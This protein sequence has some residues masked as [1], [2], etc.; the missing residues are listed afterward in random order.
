M[1]LFGGRHGRNV[2]VGATGKDDPAAAV[3]IDG[4][5]ERVDQA[6]IE[7]RVTVAPGTARVE[8]ADTA[9]L[10]SHRRRPFRSGPHRAQG[11]DPR[12]SRR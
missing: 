10:G 3:F 1:K 9:P 7:G 4:S 11:T 12:R 8:D 6:S 5:A 2:I